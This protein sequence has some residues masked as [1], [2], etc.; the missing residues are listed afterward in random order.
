MNTLPIINKAN[1]GL[2]A[3]FAC[4]CLGFFVLRSVDRKEKSV[5][6]WAISFAF[7]SIG[8]FLWSSYITLPLLF[9][10]IV[11]DFFH[12]LGFTSLVTGAYIFCNKRM[13]PKA[14]LLIAAAF[15]VWSL[16]IAL[17]KE[18]PHIAYGI[19]RAVRS[20][21]FLLVGVMLLRQPSL[22]GLVGKRLASA[23]LLVWGSFLLVVALFD[24]RLTNDL[25][26]G[27]MSGFHILAALGMVAMV[28]DRIRLKAEENE[29]KVHQLEGL[30][31]ICSYCKRIR[32]DTDQWQTLELYIEDHSHAEFS[33]GICPDCMK[34][35][36]PEID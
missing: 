21:M 18:H 5:V 13:T 19:L 3:I 2:S 6:L 26:F 4:V 16:A 9:V 15:L 7:N 34:K 35:Y 31:P 33:H 8:F 32:D 23:G 24:I 25:Q 29:K 30:L 20:A 12:M 28:I 27:I 36:H 11:G 10:Y 14:F 22:K 1:L 17:A